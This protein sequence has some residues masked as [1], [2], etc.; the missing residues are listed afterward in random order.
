MKNKELWLGLTIAL[1]LRLYLA[2]L[3]YGFWTDLTAFKGWIAGLVQHGLAGFYGAVWTD[4]PPGYM[5]VLWLT[6]K[7]YTLFD[8]YFIQINQLPLTFLIKLVPAI[9]D[10][11]TG[12]LIWRILAPLV[13]GGTM[14]ALIYVFNP[15]VIFISA[16]WGQIDGVVSFLMV[17]VMWLLQKEKFIV[18]AIAGAVSAIIKPQ[19]LFLLPIFLL[20]QWQK[21][22]I[23]Q[24]L[25]AIALGFMSVWLLVLPFVKN[26]I[27]FADPSFVIQPFQFLYKQFSSGAA[28][29]PYASV[30]GFNIWAWA[31]WRSDAT[32]LLG[33]SYRAIGLGLLGIVVVWL[34]IFLRRQGQAIY[35]V[36]ATMLMTIFMLATRMH[37]RYIFYSLAFL[38]IA[39]ASRLIPWQIYLGITL[40]SAVNVGYAYVRYN[41]QG[42]YDQL[43]FLEPWVAGGTALL[44]FG[45]FL[46]LLGYTVFYGFK[47]LP[48]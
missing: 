27:S 45:L 29:Y 46:V 9:A 47:G 13:N 28:V 20:S 36:T 39:A 22:S 41:Q 33:I 38:V 43:A 17:L 35:L 16:V 6:G 14:A 31:N 21:R 10:I 2:T 5:Y 23:W 12:I 1:G 34:G 3:P 40:T 19:G 32:T 11:G 30:N 4:Y 24:W 25:G 8:P 7:L 15:V 44:N 42:W 37:E 26:Q 18:A 48:H